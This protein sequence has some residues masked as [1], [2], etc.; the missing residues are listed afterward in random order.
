MLSVESSSDIPTAGGSVAEE[1]LA[2]TDQTVAVSSLSSPP[3]SY[4]PSPAV[5]T[6]GAQDTPANPSDVRTGSYRRPWPNRRVRFSSGELP[7]PPPCRFCLDTRNP[8]KECLIVADAVLRDKHLAA[9]EANYQKLRILGGLRPGSPFN[10]QGLSAWRNQR[11]TAPGGVNVVK[12]PKPGP[13]EDHVAQVADEPGEDLML[14]GEA[15]EDA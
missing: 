8:Q 10:C 4:Y 9:R 3:T 6:A 5:S 13:T 15:E 2:V 11:S 1:I 14:T 7:G 12:E